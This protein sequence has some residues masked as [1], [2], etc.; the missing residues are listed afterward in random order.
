MNGATF[1]EELKLK[2]EDKKQNFMRKKN[3]ICNVVKLFRFL[4][5]QFHEFIELLKESLRVNS[6]AE[7]Y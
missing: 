2:I 4:N 7:Y 5:F 1:Q 6:M 3:D